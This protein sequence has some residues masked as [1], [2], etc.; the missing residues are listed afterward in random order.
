MVMTDATGPHDAPSATQL[1]EAVR[2]WIERDVMSLTDDRLRFHARVAANA[3]A[4]VE[5]E[6]EVGAEQADAHAR[7]LERFGMADDAELAAAIRRREFGDRA[8][9]LRQMLA[10]TVV[11]KLAVANPAYLGASPLNVE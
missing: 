3:L 7:R 9:E 5:R 10:A 2:E 4:I 6:L 8:V 11:D 1:V